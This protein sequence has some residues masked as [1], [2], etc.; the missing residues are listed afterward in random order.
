[1]FDYNYCDMWYSLDYVPLCLVG[2]CRQQ[3]I[4]FLNQAYAEVEEA[5]FELEQYKEENRELQNALA[6]A[7]EEQ[8]A[9]A[10]Q[11]YETG[12][13]LDQAHSEVMST[14]VWVCTMLG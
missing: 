11:L 3:E 1:M 8:E 10:S 2:P 7:N 14:V 4:D 13:L 6:Q 9:I 5:N 12:H